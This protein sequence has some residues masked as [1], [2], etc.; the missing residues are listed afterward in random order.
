MDALDGGDDLYPLGRGS[1]PLVDWLEEIAAALE[2]GRRLHRPDGMDDRH[3][4]PVL[5]G[6]SPGKQNELK[7][8][9]SA[10][11][12]PDNEDDGAPPNRTTV[13][14]DGGT[15]VVRMPRLDQLETR[16]TLAFNLL[17]LVAGIDWPRRPTTTRL[18]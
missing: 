10:L 15:A 1:W 7:E 12:M 9:Q 3:D 2:E 6:S 18:Q 14:L 5:T 17:P 13:D 8:R 11:V 16:S 4:W